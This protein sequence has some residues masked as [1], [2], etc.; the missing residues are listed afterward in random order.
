MNL[1]ILI[2]IIVSMV[3][4]TGSARGYGRI[5][6]LG[7]HAHYVGRTAEASGTASIWRRH[8]D[9]QAER[10]RTGATTTSRTS[11]TNYKKNTK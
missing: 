9:Y 10:R 7:R 8:S 4:N 1:T 11:R 6:L 2:L 5:V 3:L